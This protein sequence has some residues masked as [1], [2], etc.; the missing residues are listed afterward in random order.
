ML[1]LRLQMRFP[2]LTLLNK[3]SLVRQLTTYFCYFYVVTARVSLKEYG[4]GDDVALLS[5]IGGADNVRVSLVQCSQFLKK[6][7]PDCSGRCDPPRTMGDGF[8]VVQTAHLNFFY[9][10]SILGELFRFAITALCVTDFREFTSN[11]LNYLELAGTRPSS[12]LF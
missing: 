7:P 12:L 11:H 8:A 4:K 5:V 3:Y 6:L 2:V 10:Q 1:R 9:N